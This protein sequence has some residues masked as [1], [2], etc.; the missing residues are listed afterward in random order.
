MVPLSER[1]D[2]GTVLLLKS[3]IV[4]LDKSAHTYTELEIIINY[5]A[6]LSETWYTFIQ[7]MM[8]FYSE[9]DAYLFKRKKLF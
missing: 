8:L 4:V 3:S 9:H 2:K 1:L 5:Y 7:I 6:I